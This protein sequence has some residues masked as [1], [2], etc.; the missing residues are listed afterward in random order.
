ML[1]RNKLCVL[2]LPTQTTMIEKDN[3]KVQLVILWFEFIRLTNQVLYSS[4][5]V[6]VDQ[7]NVFLKSI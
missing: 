5:Q 4:I 2:I 1:H 6:W 3:Y 7:E